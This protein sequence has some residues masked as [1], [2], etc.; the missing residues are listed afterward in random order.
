ME[1]K[2]KVLSI[3]F[4]ILILSSQSAAE[5][6]TVI[7]TDNIEWGL[8]N[9]LRGD[10]SPR[11]YDL[12]GDTVNIASRLESKGEAGRINVSNE[13]YNLIKGTSS[14]TYRGKVLVKGNRE[15]DMYFVE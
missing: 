6:Y 8:L 4:A 11:A 2:M 9:P 15:I 10:A 5:D 13:T 14:G 7:A 1:A 12:W 3:A